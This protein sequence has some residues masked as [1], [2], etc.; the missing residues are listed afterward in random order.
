[1]FTAIAAFLHFPTLL[2]FPAAAP[3][4]GLVPA[5]VAQAKRSYKPMLNQKLLII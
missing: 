3:L 5:T 2:L 4:A 1:L